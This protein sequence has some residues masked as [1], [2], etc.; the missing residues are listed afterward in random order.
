MTGRASVGGCDRT[1]P[2]NQQPSHLCGCW[3]ASVGRG[4]QLGNIIMD[5]KLESTGK[6][7]QKEQL[8]QLDRLPVK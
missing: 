5:D 8:P 6:F 7:Y 4:N 2:G 3:S 1:S